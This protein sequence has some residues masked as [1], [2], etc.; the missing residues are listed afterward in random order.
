[1]WHT[2]EVPAHSLN[3]VVEQLGDFLKD[4]CRKRSITVE[5]NLKS[6][7]PIH[8]DT[9]HLQEALINVIM[10]ALQ[11][12]PKGGILTIT[13]Q[14]LPSQNKVQLEIRDSGAGM[15]KKTLRRIS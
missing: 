1:K 11:A 7:R 4:E 3:T 13:T 15:D 6:Q 10:N 9:F 2:H 14:D 12:M 5:K 8:L